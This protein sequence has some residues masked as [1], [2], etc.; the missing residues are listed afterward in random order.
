MAWPSATLL[1]YHELLLVNV[2]KIQDEVF[3]YLLPGT[4]HARKPSLL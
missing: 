4:T 1:S 2:G 3:F